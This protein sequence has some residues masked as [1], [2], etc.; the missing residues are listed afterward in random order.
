ML[1]RIALGVCF[2]F[3]CSKNAVPQSPSPAPA[4]PTR[5]PVVPIV[6]IVPG[7]IVAQLGSVNVV[8]AADLSKADLHKLVTWLPDEVACLRDLVMSAR[9]VVLTTGE[10][11]QGIVTGPSEAATRACVT[12]LAPAFGF[13]TVEGSAGAYELQIP[14]NPIALTWQ[15]DMLVIT[16][17][18]HRTASG[19]PSPVLLELMARVPGDA[20]CWF[21]SSGFPKDKIK[22][23]VG[24]VETRT[25]HW[26]LTITV[27]GTEPDA[28]RRWL[29]HF[30]DGMTSTAH[31]KGIKVEAAWFTVES[32]TNTAKL[33]ATIPNGI[34]RR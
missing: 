16:K 12:R 33:V 18:G 20:A 26:I 17:V 24:W 19:N 6:P 8:V 23:L 15:G 13:S 11:A 2:L 21:A 9:I 34:F 14:D 30:I 7:S 31:G 29:E 32:T 25:D 5:V 28:A 4:Q 3:A 27:E 1:G 22:K 10:D